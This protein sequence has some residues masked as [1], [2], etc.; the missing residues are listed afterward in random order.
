MYPNDTGIG[1]S[2]TSVTEIEQQLIPAF[3]KVC[4]W[5][6]SSKLSLNTMKTEFMVFVTNS[7]LN[8]LDNS[9]VTTP[10]TLCFHNFEIKTVKHM[11]YL[12][13][14]ADDTL[15]W[16]RHTEYIS[17]KINRN[18]S[19]LKRIWNYFPKSSLITLYKILIR[20]YFR[21]YNIVWSPCNETLKDKL[22]SYT[23]RLSGL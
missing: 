3:C 10:H 11:E 9:P 6:K 14:I 15:T 8:P 18:I 7:R 20:P 22:Q 13:L 12:G 23:I 1:R 4:E 2:F 17:T 21:Y 16:D 19:V 5:L